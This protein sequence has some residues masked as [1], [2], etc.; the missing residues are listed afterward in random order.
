[1]SPTIG[2]VSHRGETTSA[3]G[4]LFP[5]LLPVPQAHGDVE[6]ED[7]HD[8]DGVVEEPEID[9]ND[10]QGRYHG[11]RDKQLRLWVQLPVRALLVRDKY[12]SWQVVSVSYQLTGAQERRRN[13][14]T[15]ANEYY[16]RVRKQEQELRDLQAQLAN[17]EKQYAD[18]QAQK[19]E[20]DGKMRTLN[21]SMDAANRSL[22]D[23]KA[24]I[25]GK[26]QGIDRDQSEM[27]RYQSEVVRLDREI[28]EL[29]KQRR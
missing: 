26:R 25:T 16:E 19:M 20:M 24:R 12:R 22:N 17:T 4:C 9:E 2:S 23:L 10:H 1:M 5:E 6:D 8:D 7:D 11:E 28:G 29:M 15:K 21:A 13:N 14:E 27:E 3:L 18:L